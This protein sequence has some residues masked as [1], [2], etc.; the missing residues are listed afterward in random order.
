MKEETIINAQTEEVVPITNDFM[1]GKVMSDPSLYRRVLEV[2]LGQ[3]VERV[4]YSNT[5]QTM[6]AY[7]ESHGVRMDAYMQNDRCMYN[8]EMQN[9]KKAEIIE[10]RRQLS[11]IKRR[12][13][14]SIYQP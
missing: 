7:Q 12:D 10:R 1:F 6:E 4:E 9:A 3:P 13:M 5:Q 14:K 2:I 8:T 11:R